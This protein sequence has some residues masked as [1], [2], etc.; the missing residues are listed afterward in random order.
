MST[1]FL[2]FEII[3]KLSFT[4][5]RIKECLVNGHSLNFFEVIYNLFF[6][7]LPFDTVQHEEGLK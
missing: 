4:L 7:K 1:V 3:S 5:F 6:I 2:L